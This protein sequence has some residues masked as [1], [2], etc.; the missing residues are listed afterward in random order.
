MR[1]L[2]ELRRRNVFKVTVGYTILAWMLVRL[3]HILSPL[4]GVGDRTIRIVVVALILV[5]PIIVLF[6]WAYEIT[7]DGLKPSSKVVRSQSITRETGRKL[8]HALLFLLAIA[9][10][11]YFADRA[12]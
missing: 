5:F 4:M 7:P 3:F 10:I 2:G 1:V 11:V 9:L 6:A 12:F 8:N